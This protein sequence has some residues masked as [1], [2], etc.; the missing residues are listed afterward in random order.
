MIL[1]ESDA[2]HNYSKK[3]LPPSH[4][5]CRV[6]FQVL[7]HKDCRV[8]LLQHL[9]WLIEKHNIPTV[10]ASF[11]NNFLVMCWAVRLSIVL[12]DVNRNTP[13]LRPL[14]FYQEYVSRKRQAAR[15]SPSLK[16]FLELLN[17]ILCGL[18]TDP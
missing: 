12:L 15:P 6:S 11:L 5:D 10:F 17:S 4:K 16:Y 2:C 7:S 1:H 18:Q 3:I 8:L 13:W 9:S 14:S